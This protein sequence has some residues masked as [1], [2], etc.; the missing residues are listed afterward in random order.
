L[1][2]KPKKRTVAAVDFFVTE[3]YGQRFYDSCKDVKFA[4]ANTRAMD[5][6]GGGA[7]NYTGMFHPF[8]YRL[9]Q[10]SLCLFFPLSDSIA[11]KHMLVC[12]EWFAFMGRE[13][14]SYEPG[15]PFAINFR[16]DT[17]EAP[18]AEPLNSS[19]AACSDPSLACSCG[20][21]PVASSCA[22]PNPPAPPQYRGC[23]VQIAGYQVHCM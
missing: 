15:S 18:G 12:S 7:K 14:G 2:Q 16:T 19:V 9:K 5:F 1:V 21:C 13:A 6:I 23:S 11:E 22:E 10:L 8:E 20:D 17:K 4:A 3:E